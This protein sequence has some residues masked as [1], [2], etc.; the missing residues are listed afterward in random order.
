MVELADTLDSKSS[1]GNLMRVRLSLSAFLLMQKY[2]VVTTKDVVYD[3]APVFL[4]R[5][6]SCHN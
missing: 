4:E 1:G 5:V 2:C 3:A 6:L